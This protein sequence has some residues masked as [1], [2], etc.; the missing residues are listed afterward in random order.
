MGRYRDTKKGKTSKYRG[1]CFLK[2]GKSTFRW[3]VTC[4]GEYVGQFVDEVE[5]A[6]AYDKEARL[7]Y[8][9][10]AKLNFPEEVK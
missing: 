9:N 6:K 1:V 4:D 10:E 3:R 7:V 5:A 8:G 2:T